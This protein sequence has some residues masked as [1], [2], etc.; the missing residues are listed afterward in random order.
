MTIASLEM[1][2]D[3]H[4]HDP[5]YQQ[6]V[7]AVRDRILSGTL[8]P[9]QRLPT[10]RALAQTLGVN[11]VTTARAYR[12]L[13]ARGWVSSR[14][15][16][17]TFVC[18]QS[19]RDPARRADTAMADLFPMGVLRRL[20]NDVIDQE[21]AGAF[22]Y[23]DAGGYTGLRTTL[24]SFLE[25]DGFDLSD[26][27]VVVFSGAQQG[28]SI[29][30]KV[31]VGPGDWVLVERPTYPGILR[32]LERSGARVESMD[33]SSGG[34]DVRTLDRLFRTRPFRLAYV[35]PTFQNPTGVCYTD[36]RK[37]VLAELCRE[38]GVA[39]IEDDAFSDLD[40][41]GG[42]ARPLRAV[43][44]PFSEGIY[45]KS[46]SHVMLPGF[47][48]GFCLCSPRLSELVRAAKA[49]ADLFSSGFFQR[50][51]TRFIDGSH[52][53]EHLSRLEVFERERLQ[54]V[55]AAVAEPFRECGVS[56]VVPSG[57]VNLWCCL[58]SGVDCRHFFASCVHLGLPVTRGAEFSA[59]GGLE[60]YFALSFAE[61]PP[62]DWE[63]CVGQLAAL[64]SDASA[65]TGR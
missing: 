61:M 7:A 13:A 24:A 60:R 45:L 46:F 31:L 2:V 53:S 4:L 16:R 15:G 34:P 43:A 10:T 49:E 65:A 27:E 20:L 6:I 64:V 12:E 25:S 5:L 35:M 17:G 19:G 11:P 50:V 21:G 1:S 47:R 56:Y 63:R 39:L 40:Y 51:L 29:L 55:L 32:L 59:S 54:S 14:V 3:P 52:F 30:L 9:G 28:L 44:A 37:R 57:G 22:A 62:A 18:V 38:H 58:P 48:L 41:G 36:D 8:R 42:R 33:L 23:D 26:H